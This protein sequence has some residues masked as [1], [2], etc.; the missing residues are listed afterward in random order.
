MALVRGAYGGAQIKGS[1]AGVSFQQS[2]YGTVARNRTVPVNPNSPFQ[3]AIK[4]A[5]AQRSF[6]WVNTLT[7]AQRAGWEAYAAQ[8]P[9]PD[10]FGQ[11]TPTKGRQMF[12]RYNVPR[13]YLTGSLVPDAP[14]TPGV[15]PTPVIA[16]A[17]DTTDGVTVTTITTTLAVGDI[18]LFRIG[19]PVSQAKNFYK[20]PFTFAAGA[21]ST[22]TLP[23]ELKAGALVAV[24][25]RYFIATR[26]FQ[27]DGK[28]SA[29]AIYVVDVT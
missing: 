1:I 7:A 13:A 12:L 2:P 19:Q 3:Q 5:L 4:A 27:A 10:R 23:L 17:G 11:S 14:P 16:L 26:L 24:G 18:M 15:A 29:E 6:D 20:A 9:L 21:I 8:T 25:Q 28:V 22:T